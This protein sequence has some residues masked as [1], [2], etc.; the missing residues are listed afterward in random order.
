MENAISTEHDKSQQKMNEK[1]IELTQ[2][3][4]NNLN[5]FTAGGNDS[6]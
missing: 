6:L 5:I 2:N 1:S 3:V 4:Q